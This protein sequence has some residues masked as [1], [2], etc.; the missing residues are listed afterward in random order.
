[1]YL[2]LEKVV[3]PL[4]HVCAASISPMYGRCW[5]LFCLIRFS[6]HIAIFPLLFGDFSTTL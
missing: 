1:M 5:S 3:Y 4:N 2:V 6:E